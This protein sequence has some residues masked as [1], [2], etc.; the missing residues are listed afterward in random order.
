MG[1]QKRDPESFPIVRF[2]K[3]A[4]LMCSELFGNANF[5]FC[6]EFEI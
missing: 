3:N 2:K 6:S 4:S 1:F 5:C